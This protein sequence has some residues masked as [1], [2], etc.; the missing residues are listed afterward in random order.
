MPHWC[1]LEMCKYEKAQGAMTLLRNERQERLAA[2]HA[3]GEELLQRYRSAIATKA[4]AEPLRNTLAGIERERTPLV[5]AL[6]ELERAHADLPQPGDPERVVISEMIDRLSTA[7]GEQRS[8]VGRLRHGD[9]EWLAE[10]EPVL[11]MGW[12]PGETD[13]LEQ[14]ARH[15]RRAHKTLAAAA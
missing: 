13:L 9:E 1:S 12:S 4:I 5:E 3:H 10:L 14:L 15:L 8:L 7:T 11:Q 6:A 2:L